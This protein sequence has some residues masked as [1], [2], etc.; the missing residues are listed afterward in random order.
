MRGAVVRD[1]GEIEE[2][3]G[4]R[5]EAVD[6]LEVGGESERGANRLT[7]RQPDRVHVVVECQAVG[8]F[9]A[10]ECFA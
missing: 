3:A 4:E 6:V 1:L 9:V 5:Q 7:G 10:E 2:P 8:E